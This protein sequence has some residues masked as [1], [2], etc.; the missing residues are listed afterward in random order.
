MFGSQIESVLKESSY[1]IYIGH[2]QAT[3][4]LLAPSSAK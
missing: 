4:C 2:A 3:L 1:T